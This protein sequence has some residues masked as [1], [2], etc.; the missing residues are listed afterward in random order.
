MQAARN[1]CA[2][3][4]SEVKEDLVSKILC[5]EESVFAEEMVDDVNLEEEESQESEEERNKISAGYLSKK[6]TDLAHMEKFMRCA[7][8]SDLG[9]VN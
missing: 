8:E 1:I 4:F 6:I 9:L 2:P 5:P 3:G 7:T